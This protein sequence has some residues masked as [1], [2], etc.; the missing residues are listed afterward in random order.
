MTF[1]DHLTMS[2]A[3]LIRVVVVAVRVFYNGNVKT[4]SFNKTLGQLGNPVWYFMTL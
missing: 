2:Y 3:H 4:A 1:N